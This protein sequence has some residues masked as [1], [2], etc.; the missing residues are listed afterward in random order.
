MI[1]GL[2]GGYVG[3]NIYMLLSRY[4]IATFL[5]LFSVTLYG[6]QAPHEEE[7]D[8]DQLCIDILTKDNL[9][10]LEK[11]IILHKN[12][13]NMQ[14]QDDGKTPLLCAIN[15]IV[16][17]KVKN[18][19]AV[20]LLLKHGADPNKEDRLM[21]TNPLMRAA[22]DGDLE[23]IKEL[24]KYNPDVN[25]NNNIYDQTILHKMI[26]TIRDDDITNLE[27]NYYHIVELILKAGA[28]PNLE[29]GNGYRILDNAIEAEKTARDEKQKLLKR[30]IALLVTYGA[31]AKETINIKYLSTILPTDVIS[32]V[33]F[34]AMIKGQWPSP[35]VSGNSPGGVT[36]GEA[37][38]SF[39]PILL[40]RKKILQRFFGGI[41]A[42][43]LAGG[44]MAALY[45]YLTKETAPIP[46]TT[47]DFV[48]TLVRLFSKNQIEDAYAFADNY[49]SMLIQLSGEERGALLEAI[50]KARG[51]L[52]Q[53]YKA[54][55]EGWPVMQEFE[56]WRLGSESDQ[57]HALHR[58]ARLLS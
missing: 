35:A 50:N 21:R 46:T 12:V 6:A 26:S 2:C 56:K 22:S 38:H 33:N 39:S 48:A 30:I 44:G 3:R 4:F 25:W 9:E 15:P 20:K 13:L 45:Y 8:V 49:K 24:M 11:S 40:Q 54:A 23:I 57:V 47:R 19:D 18:I 51:S 37:A 53:A 28:N 32:K 29:D 10:E 36:T 55:G 41:T 43:I 58:L 52:T 1:V 16:D 14:E 7:P 31:K 42:G 5:V 34:Y 27:K 17:L